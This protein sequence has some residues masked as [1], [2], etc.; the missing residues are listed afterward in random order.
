MPGFRFAERPYEPAATLLE[1]INDTLAQR[2][3]AGVVTLQTIPPE[4]D[5]PPKTWLEGPASWEFNLPMRTEAKILMDNILTSSALPD[6][7]TAEKVAPPEETL[8]QTA[9]Q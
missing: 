7:P 9:P 2:F 5:T 8:P 3:G 1:H 6:A 4:D